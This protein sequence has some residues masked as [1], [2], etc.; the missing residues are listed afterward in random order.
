MMDKLTQQELYAMAGFDAKKLL[1]KNDSYNFFNM[2]EDLIITGLTN[3]NVMDI[4][5]LLID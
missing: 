2:L 3:T 4:Q 1:N 5:I